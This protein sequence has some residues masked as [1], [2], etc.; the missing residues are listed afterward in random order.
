LHAIYAIE[1]DKHMPYINTAE[2]VGMEKGIQQGEKI[3]IQCPS[4]AAGAV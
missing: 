2:R 1:E 4:P 3:G